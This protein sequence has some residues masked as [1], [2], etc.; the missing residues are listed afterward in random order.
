MINNI[1]IIGHILLVFL[2]LFFVILF[3]LTLF[4]NVKLNLIVKLLGVIFI[5]FLVNYT[6]NLVNNNKDYYKKLLCFNKNN[7]EQVPIH[8]TFYRYAKV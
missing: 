4:E 7:E 5:I 1:D 6:Y 3:T 2:L 8:E